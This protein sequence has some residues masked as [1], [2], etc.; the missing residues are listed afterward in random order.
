MSLLVE[1]ALCHH[2]LKLFKA[3]DTGPHLQADNVDYLT[4]FNQVQVFC[5]R[6]NLHHNLYCCRKLAKVTNLVTEIAGSFSGG[7]LNTALGFYKHPFV[8]L[9]PHP[10]SLN[11]PAQR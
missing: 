6:H 7:T 5:G 3:N 8:S 10:Y 2:I 4:L 1:T 9:F 11:P